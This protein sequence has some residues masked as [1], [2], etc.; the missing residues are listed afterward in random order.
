MPL[1]GPGVVVKRSLF[2]V[3]SRSIQVA[4]TVIIVSLWG[5]VQSSGMGMAIRFYHPKGNYG[6]LSNFSR[7]PILVDNIKWPTVEHYF[8]A[9]KFPNDPERQERIRRA[10]TP[11]EAKRIAW[12]KG[13]AIR[14]DW[15][16]KRDQ[17]M[18]RALRLKFL[19]H[20]TL[21][22]ALLET[23]AE[24]LIE[25]SARDAYWGD[26]GDGR[27]LNSQ[28]RLLMQVRDELRTDQN[29]AV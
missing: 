10:R 16:E 17:I 5:W 23:N 6:F 7:D 2:T 21:K 11:T 19:Q 27:G 20:P 12:E 25:H 28:G 24:E 1:A 26:G 4:P 29:E 8:Q 14:R 22:Q 15:D 9:M 3:N 13:A 18:L